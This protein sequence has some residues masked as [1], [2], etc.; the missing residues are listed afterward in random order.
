[1]IKIFFFAQLREMLN[2]EMLEFPMADVMTVVEI[3]QELADK[4]GHWALMFTDKDLLVAVNQVIRD[5]EYI[6]KLGDEVAFFPPVT[7]G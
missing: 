2:L 4:G 5:D 6:V 1:M 7:G 3:K